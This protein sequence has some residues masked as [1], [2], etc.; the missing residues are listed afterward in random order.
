M[1][2]NL[3]TIGEIAELF[4]VNIRTLRYYDEIGILHPEVTDPQSGYRYY[5]TRQFE[6]LNSIRY[7]RALGMSL[8]KISLFFDNRDISTLRQ[9]LTEQMEETNL[10][11]ERLYKIKQKLQCRLDSLEDAVDSSIGLISLRT[12]SKRPIAFLRKEIPLGDDLEYPIRELERSNTLESSIFLG[13]VGVSI[14]RENLIQKRFEHFSGIFMLLE[15]G[16]H[17]QGTVHFLPEGDYVT[18]RLRGT[19][20]EAAAYYQKLFTYMEENGYCCDGDSV[21]I[22]LIDS[23]FTND[24]EQYVTELQIPV[25]KQET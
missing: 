24:T 19:H 6:R 10:Q 20:Q 2:K 17:Y 18:V 22:T 12:F 7:L 11:M 1:M 13:K 4:G 15:E 16:D 3:F 25:A 9:L 21:E 23:G 8:Q 14:S 5:S